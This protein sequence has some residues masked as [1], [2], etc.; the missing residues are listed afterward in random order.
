MLYEVIT[1]EK[2]AGEEERARSLQARMITEFLA[3]FTEKLLVAMQNNEKASVITS[4]SIHYTKLY[5]KIDRR[6]AVAHN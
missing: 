5:E 1:L 6:V 2:E 3:P 4:Y